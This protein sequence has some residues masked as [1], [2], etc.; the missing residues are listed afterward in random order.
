MWAMI[1]FTDSSLDS[2]VYVFGTRKFNSWG[3]VI[4]QVELT[5]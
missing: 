4:E 1:D 5:R 2:I 3:D